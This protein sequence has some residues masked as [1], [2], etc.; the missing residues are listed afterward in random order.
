MFVSFMRRS[1]DRSKALIVYVCNQCGDGDGPCRKTYE[2][3]EKCE[4]RVRRSDEV[5]C[6]V[7]RM[8]G[9]D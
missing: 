7:S 8:R 1:L 9:D 2:D 3:W 4:N 5:L 6:C